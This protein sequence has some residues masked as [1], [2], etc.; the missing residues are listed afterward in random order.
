MLALV[1]TV[2]LCRLSLRL[3][4]R[5]KPLSALLQPFFGD[6]AAVQNVLKNVQ[7]IQAT[8]RAF[9]A[10]VTD[11]SVVTWGDAEYGGDSGAVHKALKN[12]QQIQSFW[13]RSGAFVAIFDHD[14]SCTGVGLAEV[15][16]SL[17]SAGSAEERQ[18]VTRS[19][20]ST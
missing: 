14:P 17:I 7:Q 15:A 8:S 2:A 3:F 11:G 10:I 1:V 4:V 5:S 18:Q 6:S 19:V 12:V 13:R 20:Q 9:A 16:K